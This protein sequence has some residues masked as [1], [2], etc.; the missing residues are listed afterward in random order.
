LALENYGSNSVLNEENA[1]QCALVLIGGYSRSGRT[2]LLGEL[3]A[4]AYEV[5]DDAGPEEIV[6]LFSGAR[7]LCAGV[8]IAA[9]LGN[10]DG[11][12]SGGWDGLLS[13]RETGRLPFKL[14]F[15]EAGDPVLVDRCLAG[16][17]I[18]REE[19]SAKL[20]KSRKS[21]EPIRS[22]AGLI[23]NSAYMP[24]GD[25]ADRVDALVEG[26][27]YQVETVVEIMSFGFQYGGETGD[28]VLD[29]R[30]LPN[31]YYVNSLRALTGK[32]ESCAAY[33]LGF[34]DAQ[35]TL[36]HLEKLTETMLRAFREQGRKILTI[37]IG[38][39][40]GQ[41]RSVALAEAL[42]KKIKSLACPVRI[43]HREMEAR[44]YEA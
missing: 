39:T 34:E 30:F 38:C 26:R 31:P 20:Q 12:A 32:D 36:G 7:R 24:P 23:L 11:E 29:I 33:V 37:R 2:A 4:R 21:F 6:R 43:R 22:K 1:G 28:L 41:H 18:S 9:V 44:R 10:E 16:S 19:A 25:E 15:V 13:A 3:Q 42:A 40:G 5:L 17:P 35:K 27:S 8:K 14:V